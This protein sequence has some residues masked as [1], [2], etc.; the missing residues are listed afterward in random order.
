MMQNP[1]IQAYLL[2]EYILDVFN[3][4]NASFQAQETKVHLLQSAAENLLK[5]ILHIVVKDPL[6][7]F[8]ADGIINLNMCNHRSPDQVTVEQTCQDQLNQESQ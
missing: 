8:V 3:K 2:L 1:E 6:L 5:N 4:F 7:N